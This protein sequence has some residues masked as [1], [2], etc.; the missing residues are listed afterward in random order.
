MRKVL[1]ASAGT[2]KTYRL[3][4][5]YLAAI[6]SGYDFEEIV[7]MTF[8][9]K[10]TA[11]IRERIFQHIEEILQD[12]EES[13]VLESL[14]GIYP[15]LACDLA[16]LESVYQQM[17]IN[18]DKIKIFTIDSFINSIFKK[19]IAPYLDIYAYEIIDENSNME[20]IEE[21]FKRMLDNPADFSLL[22][23]FLQDNTERFIDSYL[24]LIEGMLN[25]RWKFLLIDYRERE[26]LRV[27]GLA[28]KLDECLNILESIAAGKGVE[29]TEDFYKKAYQSLMMDYSNLETI[30]EKED[31]II[32][33]YKLFFNDNFWNSSKIRGKDYEGLREALAVKYEEFLI[34][35]AA[36]I[37]NL[38]MIPYEEEI[39]KFSDRIFQLYDDIKFREKKFTHMDISNYTYMYFFEP[40]LALLDG[41]TVSEYFFELIGGRVRA[42]FIDEFQDTSI[43]QWKILKPLLDRCEKVIT[44]GD[45]K[46]SIYGWR[47]GEKELFARL[48]RILAGEEETLKI[49]YRSER[50]IVEFIN[51][52]FADINEDWDYSPVEHLARKDQGYLEFLFGGER[53]KRNTETKSF[54]K[55]S[56][57]KQEEIIQLNERITADIKGEIARRIKSFPTYN[58]IAVL[59][60]SNQEL[61]DIAVELDRE[62]IPYLLESKDSLLEHEAVKPLY[63]L[64]SFLHYHDFLDLLK[65]LRSDLVGINNKCL[66]YIIENRDMVE[67][68]FLGREIEFK[69]PGLQGLFQQIKAME[70]MNFRELSNYIIESSG[71][72]ERY[73]GNR[74]A[75]RNIHYFFQLMRGFNSLDEFMDFLRENQDSDELKQLSV[76][77]DN[78]VQLMTI[79]KAKGLSFETEFFYWNISPR[80][81]NWS[82]NLELYIEFDEEYGEVVDYLLT[83]SRYE[84][85]FGYLGIDFAEKKAG[86]ELIEEINNLYVALTRPEKNL[87]IYIE[88]PR[89]LDPDEEGRCWR[90][91]SYEFYEDA[92]L[93]GARVESLCDLI[94]QKSSGYLSISEGE[95][96]EEF[97]AL[98]DLSPYFEP[99]RV[100]EEL[101]QENRSKKDYRMNL[102]REIKRIEGLA[103]HYYLEF[104]RYNQE[105]ERRYA[106]QMVLARYGNI[107]G[108]GRTRELITR[109]NLFL[110]ERQEYFAGDWLVFNEYE[111]EWNGEL[112]RIDHLRVNK[113]KKEILILDY[114]SGITRE[115]AQLDRYKEIIEEMTG[116]EYEIRTEFVE[117]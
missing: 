36:S 80:G 12:G 93:R 59:A 76:T 3:S 112:Y 4:L 9:R 14:R 46:Q 10:A 34:N 57:E 6:L 18:K 90:G 50:E 33:H 101:I 84:K 79:H 15:G 86:R 51:R 40:E 42:L 56:K 96:E 74:A 68:Y 54:E 11:E 105:E 98:N 102:E 85:L 5:E 97:V 43:L 1:K 13:Q 100:D 23:N 72:L 28:W 82:N 111:L 113:E 77:G 89:Q 108:P 31:R 55:L 2:G 37:Y 38:E 32:R 110:Q 7:V 20:I 88:G 69:F 41:G 106:E 99:A 64:L 66:R 75:L 63:F 53:T 87:F 8:T 81:G 91:S 48:E 25:N 109:V 35:L 71:L 58:N 94:E 39:F 47:G 26:E 22:E 21:V 117:I 19:A 115:Q 73:K 45:E 60:R 44:V 29:F 62:G 114:K 78:V 67:G 49:C 70:E 104:V 17:L 116:G 65:F 16:M 52:F 30:Q 92:L 107:L 24:A 103:L 95:R 61:A 27:E 83:N